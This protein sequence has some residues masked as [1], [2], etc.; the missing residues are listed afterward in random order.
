MYT[1]NQSLKIKKYNF[2]K[3]MNVIDLINR[4]KSDEKKEKRNTLFIAAG[5]ISV[6]VV[7]GVILSF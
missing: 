6:L 2:K 7:S 1:H 3:S 5:A 4:V